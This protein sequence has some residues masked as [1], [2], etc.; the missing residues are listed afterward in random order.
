MM[1]PTI[2]MDRIAEAL[3]DSSYRLFDG[4]LTNAAGSDKLWAHRLET[5]ER[6]TLLEF[7]TPSEI[8]AKPIDFDQSKLDDARY[9]RHLIRKLKAPR[10]SKW[11][12]HKLPIHRDRLDDDKYRSDIAKV[13]AYKWVSLLQP[14]TDNHEM[15]LLLN[16]GVEELEY[17]LDETRLNL[18]SASWCSRALMRRLTYRLIDENENFKRIEQEIR[19][20]GAE[21]RKEL[22]SSLEEISIQ[23]MTTFAASSEEILADVNERCDR[24]IAEIRERSEAASRRAQEALD[25]HGIDPNEDREATFRQAILRRE[26]QMKAERKAN[27]RKKPFWVR[28]LPYLTSAAV[29]A[30]LFLGLEVN[31][32]TPYEWLL[33]FAA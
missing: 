18:V 10:P 27:W 29:S 3:L 25:R 6:I 4:V 30:G 2:S 8:K 5:F 13:L 11:V 31:G 12:R 16:A 9:R 33:L 23:A 1:T 19:R 20:V 21:V 32:K 15:F 17:L 22:N 26:A 24:A 7:V 28:C 14:F